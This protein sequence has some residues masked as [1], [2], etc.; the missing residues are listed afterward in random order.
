LLVFERKEF[1]FL[2]AEDCRRVAQFR[3]ANAREVLRGAHTAC[4]ATLAARS[5]QQ[6]DADAFGGALRHRSASEKRLVIRVRQ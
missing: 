1:K 2:N 5:A 6:A 4:S 3:L